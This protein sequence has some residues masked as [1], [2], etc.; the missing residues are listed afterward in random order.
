MTA[1][2]LKL[3]GEAEAEPILAWR[4]DK[5]NEAGYEFGDAL[6]LTVAPDVDLH[7][8]CE[9]LERGCPPQTALRIL[10]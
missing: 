2:E 9:L 3:L 10:L 1:A 5:L 6:C 8:A 4:F 7:L